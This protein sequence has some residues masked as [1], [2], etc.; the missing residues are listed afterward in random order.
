MFIS[1]NRNREL[2]EFSERVGI[3]FIFVG[4]LNTIFTH[5]SFVQEKKDSYERLEFLGDAVLKLI[6]SNYF[7]KKYK[8]ELEGVLTEKRNAVISDDTLAKL[9]LKLNFEDLILISDDMKNSS[10]SKEIVLACAFEALLGGI[11][12]EGGYEKTEKF[13]LDNFTSEIDEIASTA[14]SSN[15][16]AL[17]Q[18]YTQSINATL[19]EYSL[20]A[21]TGKS[22]DKTFTY[23]IIWQNEV[24]G[25]GSGKTK[26]QAQTF[27]AKSAIEKLKKEGAKIW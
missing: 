20:T 7:F 22:H 13:F 21:E 9:A 25:T 26:K 17:L 16:K 1:A 12:L 3:P 19:P 2:C 8:A 15:Y 24:L 5:P 23:E 10:Y 6:V 14:R 11:F 27:A 4:L 18:E